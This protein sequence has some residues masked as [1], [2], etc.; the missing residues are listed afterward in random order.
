MREGLGRDKDSFYLSMTSP[1][2][3]YRDMIITGFRTGE[4][5]PAAPGDIRAFDV[6]S[7]RLRWIFHTIPRRGEAGGETW[8]SGAWKNAGGANSWAGMVVDQARGIVFAPTGSAVD[9]FYG[10]DRKGDDL[11]A[12]CLLALDAATGKLLWHFQG[13]HHDVLDRDFPS[14]PVLLTVRHDGRMVDAV[15]Q[16]TKQ[17]Y[18]FLLDRVTGK[19]LFAVTET[20]VPPDRRAG[21]GDLADPA[22]AGA[23]CALC[24]PEAGA[25]HA[26]QPH[27]RLAPVGADAAEQLS[28]RRALRAVARGP[29]DRGDAR[30]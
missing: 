3:I 30:L 8:P 15:A 29:A 13:M 23:A 11:Y 10:A 27:G 26:D 22:G 9:D 2:V 21:R 28:P 4:A 17:G 5:A 6:H 12:N 7:G 19:P 14:P 20:A 18:L 16:A 24:P 25:G 1:G